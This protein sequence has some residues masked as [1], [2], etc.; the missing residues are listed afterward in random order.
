ME[1]VLSKVYPEALE[2]KGPSQ[3]VLSIVELSLASREIEGESGGCEAQE[4]KGIRGH[5]DWG[6]TLNLF[7]ALLALQASKGRARA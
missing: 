7:S 4:S 3:P 1:P 2:G 6:D 5:A